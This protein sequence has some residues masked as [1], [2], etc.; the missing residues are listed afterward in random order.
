M[1]DFKQEIKTLSKEEKEELFYIILTDFLQRGIIGKQSTKK[2]I[3]K[4]I[5][6]EYNKALSQDEI[7]AVANISYELILLCIL[8]GTYYENKHERKEFYELI[9]ENQGIK[10]ENVYK[11]VNATVGDIVGDR[12]F[13]SSKEYIFN[14]KHVLDILNGKDPYRLHKQESMA[15]EARNK[16]KVVK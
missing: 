8:Q 1:N 7:T 10:K 14:I 2:D 13:S 11:L 15:Q 6:D 4:Q 5:Q 12:K 16:F 9:Y 3:I